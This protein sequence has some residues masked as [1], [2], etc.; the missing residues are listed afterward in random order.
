MRTID[1]IN[2][3]INTSIN[4]ATKFNDESFYVSF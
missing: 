1:I 4:F 2:E 3:I